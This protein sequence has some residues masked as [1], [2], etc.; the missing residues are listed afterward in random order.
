MK[1]YPA[2]DLFEGKAVRLVKGD[3]DRMTVYSDDPAEVAVRFKE[4]GAGYIHT[5]DLEGARLGSP[6]NFEVIK[7]I[8]NETGL[9]VETG[10]GIRSEAS[11]EKYLNAGIDRVILGTSAVK[12]GKLLK[13]AIESFGEGIAVG[14]DIKD[15]YVA[16][17][18]WMEKTGIKAFDF[19]GQMKDI[20]VKTIICTDISRDGMMEGPNKELYKSLSSAF[21]GIDI[22]A[23]GGVSGLTDIE[24]LKSAGLSGAIIGKAYY[25]GAVDLRKAIEVADDN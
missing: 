17:S 23:S 19:F 7:R 11:I 2:I 12:D 25:T 21:S 20:G 3:Y 13:K 18:G 10:G 15:G 5:V 1:I 16:V 24:E 14:I 6:V 9:F 8:K 4:A 22:I